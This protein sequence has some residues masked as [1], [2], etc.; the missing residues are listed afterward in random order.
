MIKVSTAV[1]VFCL[2]VAAQNANH[3]TVVPTFASGG[4]IHATPVPQGV[5]NGEYRPW[6]VGIEMPVT[7]VGHKA[8]RVRRAEDFHAKAVAVADKTQQLIALEAAEAFLKW[9]EAYKKIEILG[10]T[11]K[12]TAKLLKNAAA[13]FELD[14]KTAENYLNT[15]LLN[16]QVYA[17]YNE[18]LYHHA[19]ALAALERIT[20][21]GFV[22]SYRRVVPLGHP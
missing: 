18:A 12:T 11:P 6:A 13:K 19:L 15:Q 4:D 21:G 14:P 17:M 16:A 2:E 10:E 8:D 22:P 7:L 9:K 20:A 5:S 3:H 1:E